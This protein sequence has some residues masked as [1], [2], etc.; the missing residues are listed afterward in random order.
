[1]GFVVF[2]ALLE[3]TN[4]L[5]VG[6]LSE[7]CGEGGGDFV[8]SVHCWNLLASWG[9]VGCLSCACVGFIVLGALLELTSELGV[10]LLSELCVCG[11]LLLCRCTT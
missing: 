4:E 10:G 5:G 6:L 11:F 1:M 2:G 8:V 7:L 3:L 9:L